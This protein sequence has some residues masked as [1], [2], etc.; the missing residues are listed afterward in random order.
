[1]SDYEVTFPTSGT[2]ALQ[3]SIRGNH[4]RGCAIISFPHERALANGVTDDRHD[5]LSLDRRPRSVRSVSPEKGHSFSDYLCLNDTIDCLRHGSM[6]G[7][8]K[9][10]L[11]R[12]QCV[13]VGGFILLLSLFVA[14]FG[15]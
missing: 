1:M 2:S 9:N 5:A 15:A 14:A 12:V 7:H 3:P 4:A 10:Q 6:R 8:A 11:T 13:S